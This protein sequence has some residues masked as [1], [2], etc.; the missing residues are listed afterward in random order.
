MLSA[1]DKF[2][3]KNNW[4]PQKHNKPIRDTTSG[5]C[6]VALGREK[7]S[8]CKYWGKRKA[9]YHKRGKDD[10]ILVK[11]ALQE[12]YMLVCGKLLERKDVRPL[13]ACALEEGMAWGISF[14]KR[15]ILV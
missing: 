9:A 15:V 2:V 12:V 3:D 8:I 1:E 14:L 5:F 11:T 13:M 6:L 7:V 10:D 4:T